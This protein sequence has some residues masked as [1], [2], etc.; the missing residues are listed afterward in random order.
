MRL[1]PRLAW[2]RWQLKYQPVPGDGQ[3]LTDCEQFMLEVARFR[4]A[5]AEGTRRLAAFEEGAELSAAAGNE[6]LR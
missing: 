5:D 3:P 6:E 2:R 1:P 4:F